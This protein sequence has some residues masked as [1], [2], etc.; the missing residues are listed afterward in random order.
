MK[1]LRLGRIG[2]ACLIIG[3]LTV[4]PNSSAAD[5]LVV[6]QYH[7]FSSNTPPS[8][9]INLELF[10]KHL[11]YLDENSFTVWPLEK[12][13]LNLRDGLSL[14]EKC[15]AIT[16][17]DAYISVYTQAFPRLKRKKWPVTV[18]VST[19]DVDRGGAIFMNWDQMREM[20]SSGAD[21]AAHSHSH[22]YMVRRKAGET[23]QQWLVRMKGEILTSQQRLADELGSKSLLFAYPFGEYNLDLMKI[24]QDFGLMGIAQ[25][26]GAIWSGSDFLALPRFPLSGIYG[27]MK[28]F[29]E[30]VNSLPLPVISAQ[31]RDPM[32][33]AGNST[34][35]LRIKLARVD[36][37]IDQLSCFATGQGRIP[38]KWIDQKNLYFEITAIKPLPPGRSRFNCTA[39][40]IKSNHYYWY[41]HQWIRQ[42]D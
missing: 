6:L 30:K 38:V 10:E 13:L 11:A 22:P 28:G 20:R 24:V 31:P 36:V 29:K 35:S 14:P 5:H 3:W 8:T 9:S 34:P 18:F 26:S 41:S 4:V 42:S 33:L 39:P 16:V 2:W 25:Q 37:H 1:W 19:Q 7:H 40:R 21:F 27:D 32:I 17:D 12:A 23:V 15:V